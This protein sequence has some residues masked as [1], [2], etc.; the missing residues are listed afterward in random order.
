M[1]A[2]VC[3]GERH[4]LSP[5]ATTLLLW[6]SYLS[7]LVKTPSHNYST[8]KRDQIVADVYQNGAT[9]SVGCSSVASQKE[10]V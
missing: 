4:I 8:R 7:T 1:E 5:N 6:R 10:E 2:Y 9:D 3:S